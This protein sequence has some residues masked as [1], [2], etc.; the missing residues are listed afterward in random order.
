MNDLERF[1]LGRDTLSKML[2]FESALEIVGSL[3]SARAAYDVAI[4]MANS[5]YPGDVVTVLIIIPPAIEMIKHSERLNDREYTALV[6]TGV[7]LT[8]VVKRSRNIEQYFNQVQLLSESR[9]RQLIGGYL[10]LS[11][12]LQQ[13]TYVLSNGEMLDPGVDFY[14]ANM[15]LQAYL[16]DDVGAEHY[17]QHIRYELTK[18]RR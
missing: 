14:L 9:V 3:L 2:S 4:K 10:N 6:N 11:D 12:P 7:A 1:V 17:F 13:Y 15:G 18:G 16:N 8:K 5:F